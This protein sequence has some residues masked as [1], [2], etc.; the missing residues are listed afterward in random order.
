MQLRTAF[1]DLLT[2]NELNT[3]PNFK[4]TSKPI[5]AVFG[6]D[7]IQDLNLPSSGNMTDLEVLAKHLESTSKSE[8]KGEEK[9]EKAVIKTGGK[10]TDAL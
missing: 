6:E 1:N 8:T 10:L 2:K 3:K 7:K 9:K 4:D 5:F